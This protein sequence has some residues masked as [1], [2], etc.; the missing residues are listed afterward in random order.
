MSNYG[1]EKGTIKI[2]RADYFP[3]KKALWQ[4]K[5]A[6][7]TNN[8]ET[9]MKVYEDVMAEAKGKRTFG[10]LELNQAIQKAVD[11]HTSEYASHAN[12]YGNYYKARRTD[13][14]RDLIHD[15]IK[16]ECVK[17]HNARNMRPV[18]PQKQQFPAPALKEF[19]A[20]GQNFSITFD[21]ENR[22]VCWYVPENNHAVEDAHAEGLAQKF[23]SLLST[24]N[25]TRG[26][27]GAIWGNNEYNEGDHGYGRGADSISFH[28]GPAGKEE[29]RELTRSMCH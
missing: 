14:D 19:K 17:E 18:R 12:Y 5:C 8:F 20:R 25:W 4:D 1:W 11:K 24:I 15:S 16:K 27:G 13:V 26:T 2:P 7:A 22:I 21:D 6:R 23:F 10:E 28:F 9:A 29:R 3:L